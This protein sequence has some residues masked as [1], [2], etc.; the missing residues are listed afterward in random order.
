MPKQSRGAYCYIC[1]VDIGHYKKGDRSRNLYVNRK[2]AGA[3]VNGKP[4]CIVCID[5]DV[6][7]RMLENSH[8]KKYKRN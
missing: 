3:V 8:Y 7:D 5:G 4:F 6:S 2:K 1:R